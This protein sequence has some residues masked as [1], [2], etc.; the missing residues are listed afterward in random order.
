MGVL[1]LA[2]WFDLVP[3]WLGRELK[4]ED[5]LPVE[6]IDA[7]VTR[8]A[9]QGFPVPATLRALHLRLGACEPFMHGFNRFIEPAAWK[10]QDDLLMFLDEN[11]GACQWTV[12]ANEQVWMGVGTERYPEL[13][14]LNDFL[15]VIMPY[16]LAQGG[17]PCAAD[18]VLPLANAAATREKIAVELR[19]PQI[20]RHNGLTIHGGDASMLW[21][22]DPVPNQ[23]VQHLFVS[24]LRQSDLDDLCSRFG[25]VDLG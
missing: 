1:G 14:T 7:A 12:D 6:D 5:G 23:T 11:Q 16:Q 17:W 10:L 2:G 13:L 8:M 18:M 19:W 3:G 4:P 9:A 21:W 22:L 25:F 15:A 20:V 24:C